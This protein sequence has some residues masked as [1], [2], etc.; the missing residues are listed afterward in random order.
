MVKALEDGGHQGAY[1]HRYGN[2]NVFRFSH[3][4]DLDYK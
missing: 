3:K 2:N 4:K 1:L